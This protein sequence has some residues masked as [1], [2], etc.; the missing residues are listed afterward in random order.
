SSKTWVL[1]IRFSPMEERVSRE[2]PGTPEC[3]A[4]VGLAVLKALTIVAQGGRPNK[5]VQAR[6]PGNVLIGQEASRMRIILGRVNNH[7]LRARGYGRWTMVLR[8][9]GAARRSSRWSVERWRA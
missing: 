1:C 5:G 3:Q 2:L 4:G 7:H 9:R 8:G 6:R